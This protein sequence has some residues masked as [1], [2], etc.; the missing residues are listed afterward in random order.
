MLPDY[1]IFIYLFFNLNHQHHCK[2][3]SHTT[4]RKHTH[5]Y[6]HTLS[7]P[8]PLKCTSSPRVELLL[9]N[10]QGLICWPGV[11]DS[12]LY[13]W[14]WL[15]EWSPV[16]PLRSAEPQRWE[17]GLEKE[18]QRLAPG[19]LLSLFKQQIDTL[20]PYRP[21]FEPPH[22]SAQLYLLHYQLP[23]IPVYRT[24]KAICPVSTCLAG[25]CQT[26]ALSH[27]SGSL[28]IHHP[29]SRLHYLCTPVKMV[30]TAMLSKLPA[31]A[32]LSD[33]TPQLPL[34]ESNPPPTPVS[35]NSSATNL[36]P[37]RGE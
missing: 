28:D 12:D 29:S 27:H 30:N 11:L 14:H 31:W 24:N 19:S 32:S 7:P 3:P 35:I 5:T 37:Y 23:I 1:W 13:Q 10:L 17:S 36:C 18:A 8:S 2:P 26:K 33:W 15:D 22:S 20:C 25:G 6:K 34:S 4:M 21:L 16:G 9:G